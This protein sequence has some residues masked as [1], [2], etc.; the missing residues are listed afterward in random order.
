MDITLIYGDFM[1]LIRPILILSGM[2]SLTIALIVTLV[3][4]VINAATGRGF[5]IGVQ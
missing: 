1:E 2:L 3:T 5:R 4:M